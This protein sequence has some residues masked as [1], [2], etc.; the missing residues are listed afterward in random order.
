M[1]NEKLYDA[2]GDIKEQ[3]ILEA[4]QP[5]EKKPYAWIKWGVLVACLCLVIR[6]GIIY[7]PWGNSNGGCGPT[8]CD[9]T[10]LKSHPEDFSPDITPSI[11]AQF[12]NPIEAKKAYRL[13]DNQWYLSNQLSDFSQVVT[14]YACYFVIGNEQGNEIDTCYTCYTVDSNDKLDFGFSAY[15]HD[16]SMDSGIWGL[17]YA[18]IESAL[19]EID[20][21]DYIITFAPYTENIYVWVRCSSEDLLLT[22]PTR[23]DFTGL[24]VGGIY[25]L[26]EVQDIL[27]ETKCP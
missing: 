6:I 12:P 4:K 9:T 24:E 5:K 18:E 22:Y 10:I 14:D 20:Y 23:P 8:N 7:I 1:T 19:S 17:T 13:L 26:K 16:P 15:P 25:T 2:I 3:H 27:K 11:I 21:E